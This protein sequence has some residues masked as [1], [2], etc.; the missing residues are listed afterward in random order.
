METAFFAFP[1]DFDEAYRLTISR[2]CHNLNV[3]AVFADDIHRSEVLS[4]KLRTSIEDCGLAFFDITGLNPNVMIEL[5]MGLCARKKNFLMVH[6]DKH[7]A[8]PAVK[9][10][11]GPLPTDLSGLIPF[12]YRTEY[13]LDRELRAVLR[14]ALGIGRNSAHDLKMKIS[15]KLRDHPYPL[16]GLVAAFPEITQAE[17][18]EALAAM[19]FERTVKLEGRGAGAMWSLVGR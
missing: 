4:D 3:R 15:Q 8:A 12:E 14:Q 2:A 1:Y 7:R 11:R 10:Y 9:A 19:K 13:D 5:G 17:I 6:P 16:R 18:E